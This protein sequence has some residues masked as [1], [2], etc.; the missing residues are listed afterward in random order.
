MR[1][2][3]AVLI[4]GLALFCYLALWM[5]VVMRGQRSQVTQAFMLYL[6][7]MALW[8]LGALMLR[9]D[10]Q[11]VQLWWQLVSLAATGFLLPLLAFVRAYLRMEQPRWLLRAAIAVYLLIAVPLSLQT[12]IASSVAGFSG[13]RVEYEFGPFIPLMAAFWFSTFLAV[14][15]YLIIGY[16]RASDPIQRNRIR[17]PLLGLMASFLGILTNG[18]P[19][20]GAYPL[21][22]ASNVVNAALL[23]YAVA[24][25]R[26]L[27]LTLVLRRGLALG[28][29]VFVVGIIYLFSLMVAQA[30][31]STGWLGVLAAVIVLA[32]IVTAASPGVLDAAQSTVDRFL[33]RDR[34]DFHMM[35]RELSAASLSLRPIDELASM[36]LSRVCRVMNVTH[37][38]FLVRDGPTSPLHLLTQVGY[39][40]PL[41][42]I[43][44]PADHP[45]VQYLP[46]QEQVMSREKMP[47][48]PQLKSMWADERADLE[49]LQGEL[50]VSVPHA[51][52]LLG[53]F[54]LGPKGD[55]SPY[56]PDDESLLA[57]LA[58]QVA[59]AMENA[60]L[61][62]ES[63]RLTESLR[64]SLA[65]LQQRSTELETSLTQLKT[66]QAQLVQAA[67]LAAL[68]TLSAGI[69][70]ELNN[71]LAG[72]KLYAQNLLHYQ[73]N[74]C[75][76]EAVLA[77]NLTGI[78]E[79]VGK[80]ARI[81]Q[82]FRD[83]SRKASG[84]FEL[85]DV[86]QPVEDALNLLGEQ[87]R[88]RNI[89]VVRDL[90]SDLPP[91]RGDTTQIEQVLV[92]LITNGR[93]ALAASARK[94]LCLHT[95]Q[96]DGAVVI[97][98][99]DTG[100]GIPP[101]HLDKIFDPFFTTKE[102]GEGVGLGLS[103][104]HG[105]VKDHGG[106]IEV[107]STPGKGTTFRVILP[108]AES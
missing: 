6:L 59:V 83:F 13:G 14:L 79:L 107:N 3:F 12:G 28:L 7:T 1:D 30:L 53:L 10:S 40:P 66:T 87:L 55:G 36:L 75:L 33:F 43:Q 92:N 42:D 61:F 106:R 58:S 64:E 69:A 32:G 54:V 72:I 5:F 101:Q 21:D 70:H 93:D 45:L 80:A 49:R 38:A 48:V 24:R 65:A 19:E 108:V 104:S 90:A 26:L 99:A 44:M 47:L 88:I 23:T 100:C 85:V 77:E 76:T 71:P 84:R 52:G 78:D 103:I 11:R 39:T 2:L 56:S 29:I 8:S 67:K 35:L 60:R 91:V 57:M 46:Q 37:G 96:A 27:D 41:D 105:I 74:G 31:F 51:A 98:V 97:E 63:K 20:L 18:V 62:A 25:Y 9:L 22:N 102:V 81:I 86:N 94:E 95:Y 89:A 68:G 50:I 73:K 17:Y 34:Y 4:P 82:H 16:R 15:A